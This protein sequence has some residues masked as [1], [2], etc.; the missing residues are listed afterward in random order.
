MRRLFRRLEYLIWHRG[1]DNDFMQEVE[2][3]R[4]MEAERLERAGLDRNAAER[5]S[6]R[7]M[8]NV[9]L[10]REDA[11]AV[12]IAPWFESVRRDVA[13]AMR[14]VVQRPAFS[15]AIALVMGLGIGSTAAVFA[16]VDALVLESLPVEQPEQLVFVDK[17]SFSYPVFTELRTRGGHLFSSL[18]AW[19]VVHRFVQWTDPLEP[20]QVLLASGEFYSTLGVRAALGRTFD[21]SD[22]RVGGGNEGFVAVISDNCWTRR[23]SRDPG[24][25]GRQVR[26]EHKSFTIV[27]V[28]PPNFFGVAPGMS[29]DITVPLTTV[30]DQETLQLQ[31]SSWLH[32]MGRLRN[33]LSVSEANAEFGPIWQKVLDATTDA[34]LPPDRR[35]WF[36]SRQ[37]A[38]ISARTGFSPIRN[39]FQE[40][41]WMLFGLVGLML[42]VSCGSA[43][44]LLLARGAGRRREIAVRLAVGAT[45]GRL[46]RQMLTEAFIW[47]AIGA[48][49]GLLLAVWGANLLVRMMMTAAA[50]IAIDVQPDW[51]FLAIVSALTLATTAL[52]AVLPA[53]R[54]TRVDA[55]GELKSHGTVGRGVFR[56]WSIGRALVAIQLSLTM[57]LLTGAALLARSL[58][59]ILSQNAGFNSDGLIVLSTDPVAAGYTG[60][61]LFQYYDSLLDRLRRLPSIEAASL[62]WHPPIT[63]DGG[64]WSQSVSVDGA[65]PRRDASRQVYFNGV[66]PQY[67]RT[68]GIPLLKGRDFTERD[69]A[70][71][72]RVVI[73]NESLVRRLFNGANPIG[74]RL[75]VG[76]DASRRDLEIVGVVRDSKYQR[77]QEPARSI[78]YVP[79][80]QLAEYRVGSNLIAEIRS[81]E[82]KQVRSAI[83]REVQALD[84]V[85]P[86]RIESADERVADSLVRER[87]MAALA[88]VLGMAALVL[89]C[90]AVYGL[91]AHS[92]SRQT[93]EIGLRLALGASRGGVLWTVLRE[94]LAVGS[95]GIAFAIPVAI[96]LG[97]SIRALLF[98][99][100]PLDPASLIGAALLLLAVATTA[101]LIPARRAAA[102]DPVRALKGE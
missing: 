81:A 14:L 60:P 51:R 75:T 20:T 5:A 74:R 13:Y 71:S 2:F 23:F 12:W 57:L 31:F 29:P 9:T 42:A 22:D 61:R 67:I 102:V 82:G 83:S 44:N 76:L 33:D 37:T 48:A 53:L 26:I 41:L 18:F 93:N 87:A 34:G 46:V 8:G 85:V 4:A 59:D 95:I 101:G 27:G 21:I 3:H 32:L 97:Q 45:R 11:R 56:R 16:L 52:S 50:P 90:A 78:A 10:A 6:R 54:A 79:C 72:S 39:Q 80:E 19:N 35:A 38:L 17:P 89:A 24:V 65:M 91:V 7:T 99:V 73:V 15:G 70:T 98:G 88:A 64:S 94:S 28:T 66:S 40:P 96:A 43:S 49:T 84:G 92:V 30:Q 55:G 36:L 58:N 100:T 1:I 77:L 68:A 69:T 63:G 86:Y 62:S 25:I 47:N